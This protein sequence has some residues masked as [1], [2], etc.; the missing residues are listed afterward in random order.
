VKAELREAGF[1]G[2]V[3]QHDGMGSSILSSGLFSVKVTIDGTGVCGRDGPDFPR[4]VIP[5]TWAFSALDGYRLTYQTVF[6]QLSA[7]NGKTIADAAPRPFS[8]SVKAGNSFEGLHQLEFSLNRSQLEPLEILRGATSFFPLF[9]DL[10][11]PVT[12]IREKQSGPD[13]LSYE[14]THILQGRIAFEISANTWSEK[15]APK[16]GIGLIKVFELPAVPLSEIKNYERA[17]QAFDKAHREFQRG[18][19]DNAVGECRKAIDV[20][21]KQLRGAQSKDAHVLTAEF[22]KNVGEATATW[23]MAMLD[24]TNAVSNAPHHSPRAHFGRFEA[25]MI[26]TTT[27]SIVAYILRTNRAINEQMAP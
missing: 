23:L 11:V 5:T 1:P 2:Q 12:A 18:E 6:A 25:Q 21:R 22:A 10:Q 4:M 20:I 9:L 19:Y 7:S 3:E 27:L 14:G 8:Y 16:L 24:A 26:L 13:V 17:Y 15:V